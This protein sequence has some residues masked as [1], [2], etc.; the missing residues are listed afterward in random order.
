MTE[1]YVHLGNEPTVEECPHLPRADLN[2]KAQK[3]VGLKG[4]GLTSLIVRVLL[5]AAGAI[6]IYICITG[7]CI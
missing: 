1:V 2:K 7:I 6:A 4:A 5:L 3:Y